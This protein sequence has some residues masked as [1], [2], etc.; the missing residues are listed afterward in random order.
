MGQNLRFCKT[1][2]ICWQICKET[3]CSK[4]QT[5]GNQRSN[6]IRNF[7]EIGL[8]FKW[9]FVFLILYLK[10]FWSRRREIFF[11]DKK[12]NIL[13]ASLHKQIILSSITPPDWLQ[14]KPF[15]SS[16]EDITSPRCSMFHCEAAR[17]LQSRDNSP[18]APVLVHPN[19]IVILTFPSVYFPSTKTH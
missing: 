7:L 14:R 4:V 9:N 13:K 11:I 5:V 10:M 3:K 19:L 17:I 2:L 1:H 15:N 18:W 8:D 6:L 12:W 16:N